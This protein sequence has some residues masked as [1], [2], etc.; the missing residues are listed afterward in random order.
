MHARAQIR[1]AFV[2]ALSGVAGVTTFSGRVFPV[3]N[4]IL[5]AYTVYTREETIGTESN[6]GRL[7]NPPLQLR[8][9][10]TSI[11][12]YAKTQGNID[13]ELDRLCVLAEEAIFS[14][15]SLRTLVRCL[16]LATTEIEVSQDAENRTGTVTMNFSCQYITE[17]GAPEVILT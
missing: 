14:D 13:D 5:P 10:T 12:A 9:V 1:D 3:Y 11:Q 6:Q 15:A 16:D 8:N 2:L 7:E 17:D 4:D